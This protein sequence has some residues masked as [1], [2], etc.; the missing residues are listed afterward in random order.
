MYCSVV[1]LFG[2]I[3]EIS[4]KSI[5][6]FYRDLADRITSI[7]NWQCFFACFLREVVGKIKIKLKWEACVVLTTAI[8]ETGSH[9]RVKIW[10]V[11]LWN[12]CVIFVCAAAL[13]WLREDVDIPDSR[14]YI[15][16]SDFEVI[17]FCLYFCVTVQC[18]VPP[19]ALKKNE[20]IIYHSSTFQW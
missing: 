4:G 2:C 3:S 8:S 6:R 18:A 13:R 12:A 19:F 17:Y 5:G 15:T 1:Y 14:L 20:C 16:L 9:F 7:I 10:V 11:L